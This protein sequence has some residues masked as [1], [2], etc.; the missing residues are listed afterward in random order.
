MGRVTL[1]LVQ[2]GS[3]DPREGPGWVWEPRGGP[4]RVGVPSG[5]SG[6]GGGTHQMSGT[7]RGTLGQVW[8]VSR[9]PH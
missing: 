5:S 7:G 3:G 8:A 1:L 4:G 9:D 6:T 2:D